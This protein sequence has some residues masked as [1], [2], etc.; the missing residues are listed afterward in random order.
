SDYPDCLAI[1]EAKVKP[2]RA[3]NNDKR[4]RDIW[5]QFTRPTIDLYAAIARLERVI[6][7]AATSQ[8]LAFA[9]ASSKQLFS[10]ATYV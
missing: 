9:F 10:H 1:V 8:T 5:W 3:S 7:I 4:R 2:E 6:V